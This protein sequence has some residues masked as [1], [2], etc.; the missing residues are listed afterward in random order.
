MG[1]DTKAKEEEKKEGKKEKEAGL[2][3]NEKQ[4][5]RS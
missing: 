3:L 1:Q 2:L 5:R 4:W